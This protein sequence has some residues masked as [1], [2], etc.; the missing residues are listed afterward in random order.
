MHPLTSEGYSDPACATPLCCPKAVRR[1]TGNA[2]RN[3]RAVA[4]R[5]ESICVK[6]QKDQLVMLTR[7]RESYLCWSSPRSGWIWRLYQLFLLCSQLMD[8]GASLGC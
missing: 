7:F 8:F 2:A 1:A 4:I 5:R 3:G 6:G